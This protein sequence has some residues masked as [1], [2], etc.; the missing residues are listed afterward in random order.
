MISF[1]LLLL[2]SF[3]EDFRFSKTL[4]YSR[5]DERKEELFKKRKNGEK[6]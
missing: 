3:S 6:N 4:F 1:Y 2:L 5:F